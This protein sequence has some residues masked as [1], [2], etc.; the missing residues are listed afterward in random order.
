M[1]ISECAMVF[2][3]KAPMTRRYTQYDYTSNAVRVWIDNNQFFTIHFTDNLE[4][5]YSS[6]QD[7]IGELPGIRWDS[8]PIG[9]RVSSWLLQYATETKL[10]VKFDTW[11]LSGR[12]AP[13]NDG[14]EYVMKV[15][16]GNSC[17]Y[18]KATEFGTFIDA[19]YD[20]L[21]I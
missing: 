14:D 5:V 1:K 9:V 15:D 16:V 13:I 7:I 11:A 10:N 8:I 17:V 21:F 19:Q 20:D 4:Y 12:R 3:D 2:R 6:V 18:V